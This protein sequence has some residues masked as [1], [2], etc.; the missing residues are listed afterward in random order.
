MEK[1]PWFDGS[2]QKPWEP[3]PYEQKSGFFGEVGFQYWDGS[4]WYAW[5]ETVE[6][7]MRHYQRRDLADISLQNDPWRGLTKEA[8]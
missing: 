4:L 5:D 1:T 7:A 3:G 8:K 2:K 6:G